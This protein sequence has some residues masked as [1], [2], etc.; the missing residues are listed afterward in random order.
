MQNKDELMG[1]EHIAVLAKKAQLNKRDKEPK[2]GNYILKLNS[3]CIDCP[4][5][6]IK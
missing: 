4:F 1:I 3:P 6:I 2:I 5:T